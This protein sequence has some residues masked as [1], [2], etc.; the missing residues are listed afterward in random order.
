MR[1]DE[2]AGLVHHISARLTRRASIGLLAGTSLP[3]AGMIADSGAKKKKRLTLCL[4]GQ[5]VIEPKKKAKKL[6]KQGATK[7]ACQGRCPSNQRLCGA[8]CIPAGICCV[9]N[10][11]AGDDICE[12]GDCV[13][14]RCGN[15]GPCTVF[16]TAARF[17]ALQINGLDGG[18]TAC[19]S[20]ADAAN[21]AGTYRAWLSSASA[22]PGTRFDNIAKAGP[23]RLVPNGGDGGNPPPTVA[24]NFNDLLTCGPTC[25]NN[26]INRDENGIGQSENFAIWTGT[27]ATGAASADTCSGWTSADGNGMGGGA[28]DVGTGWTQAVPAPCFAA[29]PLY[30]FEQAT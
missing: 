10:D 7:G 1:Q 13:P 20:V 17:T 2:L 15:G 25:L 26:A 24:E 4:N 21:L 5:T 6:L 14:L 28:A 16:M 8:D 23:Y 22:T 19:Q 9:D 30:C 3:L 29:L 27:L 12:N 18:D 11:C